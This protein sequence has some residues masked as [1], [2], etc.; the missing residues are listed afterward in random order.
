MPTF[1][2]HPSFVFQ[3]IALVRQLEG[4]R[5][6]TVPVDGAAL[7]GESIRILSVRGF[8]EQPSEDL[9]KGT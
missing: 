8:S 9:K 1:I 3:I 6:I 5:Q 2:Y 7:S 4:R